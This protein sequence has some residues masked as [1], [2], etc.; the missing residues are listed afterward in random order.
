MARKKTFMTFKEADNCGPYDERPMLPDTID[1]QLY[2]SRND[3]R[4]PFF[5]ICEKDTMIV[6]VSG[7]GQLEFRESTVNKY[8]LEVGDFIYV[9][10]GTPHRI[11]PNDVSINYRYKAKEAGLEGVVWYCE[12]CS[13]ELYKHIWETSKQISQVGYL[14]AC[15]TFNGF[16]DLRTCNNCKEIYQK[17]NLKVYNWPNLIQE[18]ACDVPNLESSLTSAIDKW[19]SQAI[20]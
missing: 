14:R 20:T 9:P 2:L 19:P 6:Q 15:Q 8:T 16:E 10:G 13:I 1:P 7:N 12:S 4:Q 18:L 17:I 5:L 3:R 11:M